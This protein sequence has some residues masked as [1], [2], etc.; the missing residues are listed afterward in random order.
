MFMINWMFAGFTRTATRIF[1]EPKILLLHTTIYIILIF[2]EIACWKYA[3]D[4]RNLSWEMENGEAG[5]LS[6][7]EWSIWFL[8]FFMLLN[9]RILPSNDANDRRS[10]I[11]ASVQIQQG[12]M[13]YRVPIWKHGRSQL[14]P[15]D[16]HPAAI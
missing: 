4:A 16:R 7:L 15:P 1:T 13:W 8:F 2:V 10:R 11:C 6:K 3:L 12:G 9:E 5:A 14:M